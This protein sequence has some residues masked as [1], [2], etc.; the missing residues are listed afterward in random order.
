MRILVAPLD[1][2]LPSLTLPAPSIRS[3]PRSRAW[4]FAAHE[5]ID[6]KSLLQPTGGGNV[7]RTLSLGLHAVWCNPR[8]LLDRLE[9]YASSFVA[10]QFAVA[11]TGRDLGVFVISSLD[12]QPGFLLPDGTEV[13]IAVDLRLDDPGLP[14]ERLFVPGVRPEASSSNAPET[15]DLPP[16]LAPDEGDINAVDG[17]EIARR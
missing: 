9:Q 7:S 1:N 4:S 8:Q 6:N 12:E 16:N 14:E 13:S 3:L 2:L 11:E 15:V 5:L 17:E 10:L